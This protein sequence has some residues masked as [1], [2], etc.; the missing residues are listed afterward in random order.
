MTSIGRCP[1]EFLETFRLADIGS[2]ELEYARRAVDRMRFGGIDDPGV[3]H[4]VKVRI[5]AGIDHTV[6]VTLS[7]LP[8]GDP[9]YVDTVCLEGGSWLGLVPVILAYVSGAL[10]EAVGSRVLH[11]HA[12]RLVEWLESVE[13]TLEN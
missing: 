1:Y 12:G 4:Y 13:A 11:R 3:S 7:I 2:G 5:T 8:Y 6:L 10:G 9:L